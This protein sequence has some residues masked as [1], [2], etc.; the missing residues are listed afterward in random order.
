MHYSDILAKFLELFPNYQEHVT[1]WSPQRGRC[2][3]ITLRNNQRL[4]FTYQ[5]DRDWSLVANKNI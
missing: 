4:L 2:I 3:K 1:Q 5:H